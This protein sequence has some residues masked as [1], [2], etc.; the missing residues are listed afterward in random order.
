MSGTL[1]TPCMHGTMIRYH[2]TTCTYYSSTVLILQLILVA[3]LHI[4]IIGVPS[5]LFAL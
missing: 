4:E 2:D 3:A 1:I 5:Y